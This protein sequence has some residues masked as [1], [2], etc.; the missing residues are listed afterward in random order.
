[1][2]VLVTTVMTGTRTNAVVGWVLDPHSHNGVNGEK[3]GTEKGQD[4]V[5][6]WVLDPLS[7]I[8]YQERKKI[9]ATGII[10]G[11]I[12]GWVQDPHSN[13]IINSV[14][15]EILRTATI[16]VGWVL[17]SH[18]NMK[19]APVVTTGGVTR[20]GA[21]I[22]V[23]PLYVQVPLVIIDGNILIEGR[24][25]RYQQGIPRKRIKTEGVM[26]RGAPIMVIPL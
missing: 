9:E 6:G 3:I 20:G 4:R 1:M 7:P 10:G 18:S 12:V 25:Y 16:N 17:D 24:V 15:I 13:K 21:P 8:K 2:T 19:T 26:R 23:I 14:M 11:K 5:V 22:M